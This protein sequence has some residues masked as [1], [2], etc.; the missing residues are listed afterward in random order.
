M[1]HTH[2]KHQVLALSLIVASSLLGVEMPNIGSALKSIES[3]KEPTKEAPAIPQIEIPE[4]KTESV[5]PPTKSIE[6]PK[7][8]QKEPRILVK[9]FEFVGN[10]AL[11]SSELRSVIAD[12]VNKELNASELL[13]VAN[14]ITAYYQK[15]GLSKAKAFI[16]KKDIINGTVTLTI[17]ARNHEKIMQDPDLLKENSILQK[18]EG[19]QKQETVQTPQAIQTLFVKAFKLSGT[20]A[21]SAEELHAVIAE[22]ENKKHTFASL[23]QTAALITK[24]YRTKGYFVAR[25]YIPKQ[26][27]KE[28]TV[29]INVIEGNYG[30]FKLKNSSLVNDETLQGMLDDIKDANIVGV[31]TLERAMLIINDTPG[32]QVVTADVMPGEKVGTSDFLIQ[33]AETKPYSAY[34]LGD[35]YGSRYTGEYRTSFGLSAN[36]PLGYGDKLGLTG[37]VST[38]TD[39]KNGKLYYNFPLMSN[40]LRG[41]ISASKTTY[42]LAEEY[43]S[44]DA[45]GNATTLEASL[46]Y[47]LIRTRAETLNLTLGYANKHM[48]DEL[49]SSST[50]TKKESNSVNLGANYT[51]NS[52]FLGFESST[53]ASITFTYGNLSFNNADALA[54]DQTGPKTDGNYGKVVGTLEKNIAFDPTYSMIGSFRFQKALGNKNLDGSEDF[55]LGGAYGIRA[56]PDGE[57][58]AENGYIVGLEFFYALPTYENISSKASIFID[59]GYARMENPTGA[60]DPRNLSDIGLG[61]QANYKDFFAKAQF[62][63]VVGGAN[64]TSEPNYQNKVL[65]Q[66]GWVY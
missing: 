59:Q 45:V 47:P 46:I 62:A 27:L 19:V 20:S 13:A 39:L 6:T 60:T 3:S 49:R 54:T 7:A 61:Y 52:L 31:N 15:K 56:F 21:L 34:I 2:T 44:L 64:V 37:I 18:Q 8:M 11:S 23:E 65:V 26:S 55:S 41:E 42:S 38:E 29:E 36:S 4:K 16:Y 32:V 12:M 14:K 63:R 50:L 66:I 48:K 1:V 40:G 53:T 58:S 35:N 28:G 9:S 10:E 25:A 24:Y 33:T 51:E 30:A 57:L 17:R 43:K 22:E 5:A